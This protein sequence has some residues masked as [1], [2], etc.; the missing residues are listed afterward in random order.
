MK[1]LSK[2]QIEVIVKKLISDYLEIPIKTIK[3]KSKLVEDLGAD[4]LDLVELVMAIE[5][6][7]G[8][9]LTDDELNNAK[10]IQDI[11]NIMYKELNKFKN[12]KKLQ[13]P[14]INK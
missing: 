12:L 14:D 1:K 7:I 9:E 10:T 8:I 4:S 13:K 6:E 2:L 5:E 11:I 3:N